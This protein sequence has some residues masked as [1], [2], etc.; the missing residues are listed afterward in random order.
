[1]RPKPADRT[2][3]EGIVNLSLPFFH[4][5]EDVHE[6]DKSSKASLKQR[7]DWLLTMFNGDWTSSTIIHY[8]S[9]RCACGCKNPREVR[10]KAT[11]VFV[12]M[13]LGSRPPVPAVSKWGKVGQT[14]RWFLLASCLHGLLQRGFQLLY[15][16]KKLKTAAE[17]LGEELAA[18]SGA[19][20]TNLLFRTVNVIVIIKTLYRCQHAYSVQQ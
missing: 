13:V 9:V 1:M 15:G 3:A 5:L 8:C 10:M 18:L 12:G 17:E 11:A 4:M 2:Y 6:D 7:L 19:A 14:A 16:K 20:R